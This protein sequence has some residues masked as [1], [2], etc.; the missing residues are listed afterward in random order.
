MDT[1][2]INRY[3]RVKSK[4]EIYASLNQR[5]TTMIKHVIREEKCI[6]I[7]IRNEHHLD[8]KK[9]A[10]QYHLIPEKLSYDFSPSHVSRIDYS[11]LLCSYTP[12]GKLSH[13]CQLSNLSLTLYVEV[14]ESSSV[15]DTADHKDFHFLGASLHSYSNNREQCEINEFAQRLIAIDGELTCA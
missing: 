9:Y 12:C 2:Y 1:S 5:L 3:E 15:V 4:K 14:A 8:I 10:S 13:I 7:D 6:Y 11:N